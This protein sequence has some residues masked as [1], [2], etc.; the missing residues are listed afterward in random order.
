MESC[1]R[2]SYRREVLCLRKKVMWFGSRMRCM[3]RFLKQL[4]EEG[5][6]RKGEG[7]D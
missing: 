5:S 1:E 6:D 7:D 4:V 3:K 2:K